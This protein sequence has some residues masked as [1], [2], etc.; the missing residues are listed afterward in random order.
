MDLNFF[1]ELD[2]DHIYCTVCDAAAECFTRVLEG[3][4]YGTRTRNSTPEYSERP[5]NLEAIILIHHLEY[6]KHF[7]TSVIR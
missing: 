3:D 7:V 5:R 6:L 2:F 1:N 4:P